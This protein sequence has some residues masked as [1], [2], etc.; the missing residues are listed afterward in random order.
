MIPVQYLILHLAYL[1]IIIQVNI[2]VT[3]VLNP[4]G[5]LQLQIKFWDDPFLLAVLEKD[6]CHPTL[7]NYFA[8]NKFIVTLL[9]LY[10]WGIIFSVVSP[11]VIVTLRLLMC[12]PL[13]DDGECVAPGL[14]PAN[15]NVASRYLSGNVRLTGHSSWAPVR[16]HTARPVPA[17]FL[18]SVGTESKLSFSSMYWILLCPL[19]TR[20][21]LILQ[22]T[23]SCCQRHVRT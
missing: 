20:T 16:G 18:T 15:A 8:K 14:P 22:W 23:T 17:W 4:Y 9:I 6:E 12:A 13:W 1:K 3:V 10:L 7:E 5:M 2:I 11:S 19:L 21:L